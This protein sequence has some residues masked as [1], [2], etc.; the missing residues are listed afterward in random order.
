LIALVGLAGLSLSTIPAAWQRITLATD[1]GR[2]RCET[3][4]QERHLLQLQGA[5]RAARGG[6]YAR[7]KALRRLLLPPPGR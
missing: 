3:E 1:L 6:R 5:V 7:Q 2:L 4:I